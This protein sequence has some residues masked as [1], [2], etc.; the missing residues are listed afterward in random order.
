MLS[1]SASKSPSRA[2]W[3]PLCKN[4]ASLMMKLHISVSKNEDVCCWIWWRVLCRCCSIRSCIHC[5][6]EMKRV[7]LLLAGWLSVVSWKSVVKRE[8]VIGWLWSCLRVRFSWGSFQ[9]CCFFS[10]NEGAV[11]RIINEMDGS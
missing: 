10:E 8:V 9:F 3:A 4:Y 6:F 2:T 11:V 5:W 7:E 1:P